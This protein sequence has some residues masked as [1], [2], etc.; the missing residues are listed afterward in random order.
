MDRLALIIQLGVDEGRRLKPYLDTKGKMTIGTGRNLTD[1]GISSLE[2]DMML[3]NDVDS[4]I[5]DLNRYLPWWTQL[6]DV[7]QNVLVNMCFNLGIAKLLGF[8]NTLTLAHAG[9]YDS[10]ADEMLASEWAKEV[11]GR[12]T[13]LAQEMRTGMKA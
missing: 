7:R 9:N 5:G 13:R 6:N 3:D 10:A 2:C 11:G 1:V 8:T 12:A 4:H